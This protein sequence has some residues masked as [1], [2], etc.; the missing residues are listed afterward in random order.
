MKDWVAR[1]EIER[2][3]HGKAG[4]PRELEE[5]TV[6]VTVPEGR[7]VSKGDLVLTVWMLINGRL[8]E[9]YG[10]YAR[11][12]AQEHVLECGAVY[13]SGVNTTTWHTFAGTFEESDNTVHGLGM[14]VGCRCGREK[15]VEFNAEV[16]SMLGLIKELLS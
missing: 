2:M 4:V 7:E 16:D 13:R 14:Y 3:A 9:Y 5:L 15:S 12:D 1:K 6:G 11:T 8:Y 10:G